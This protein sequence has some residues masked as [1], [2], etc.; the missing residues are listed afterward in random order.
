MLD[1]ILR[2]YHIKDILDCKYFHAREKIVAYNVTDRL[3]HCS[4]LNRGSVEHVLQAKAM[5]TI[6]IS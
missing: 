4:D 5:T 2:G 3:R 1:T 6:K